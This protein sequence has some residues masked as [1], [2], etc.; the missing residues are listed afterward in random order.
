M[1]TPPID[2]KATIARAK[3]LLAKGCHKAF[4]RLV[5][6]VERAAASRA[7]AHA[8]WQEAIQHFWPRSN[9]RLKAHLYRRCAVYD[10]QF[11]AILDGYSH[12]TP[13]RPEM[14]G[15]D[16][17]RRQLD[18]ALARHEREPVLPVRHEVLSSQ[19]DRSLESFSGTRI[20]FFL[21]LRSPRGVRL[22]FPRAFHDTARQLGLSVELVAL[23]DER[24]IG[25]DAYRH[26]VI[27]ATERVRPDFVVIES[28]NPS[29]E[30]AFSAEFVREIK[31][32]FDLAFCVIILDMHNR[33]K[34]AGKFEYWSRDADR[35]IYFEPNF[36]VARS[37]IKR[38]F[39][40]PVICDETVFCDVETFRDLTVSFAGAF[41][42][43]RACWLAAAANAAIGL[44]MPRDVGHRP[45]LPGDYVDVMRRSRAALNFGGREPGNYIVTGRSWE[46]IHCGAL[47]LEEQGSRLDNFFLPHVHYIPFSS[48]NDLIDKCLFVQHYPEYAAAVATRGMTFNRQW[49]GAR[50]FWTRFLNSF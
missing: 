35:I 43:A 41:K 9:W 5:L 14:G 11:R 8:L 16:Q 1:T 12:R 50:R 40:A 39:L 34:H 46:I 30:R 20:L 42:Y 3:A 33:A 49:Y 24:K 29:D 17:I 6:T 45:L 28:N 19:A 26:H 44:Y 18:Q 4:F 38:A 25:V 15:V 2:Q 13:R 48:A 31:A 23:D 37:E 47:L 7:V 32:R 21:P 36:Q 10:R 27:A 22:I